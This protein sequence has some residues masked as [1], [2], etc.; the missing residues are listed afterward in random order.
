MQEIG[1]I[2]ILEQYLRMLSPEL[3]VW[4]KEHNPNSAAEAALLA[5]VYVAARRKGQPWSHPAWK[6]RDV[7]TSASHY[8]I[9]GGSKSPM[10]HSL[11]VSSTKT[12]ICYLCG[13]EGHTK[14]RCPRNSAQITQMCFVP[15]QSVEPKVELEKVLKIISVELNGKTLKALLDSGSTQTLIHRN[16]VPANKVNIAKTIRVCCVHGD[17]KPYTTADMHIKVQGQIYLV[18]IGVA[19]NLPFPAVL[20]VLF[21][22]LNTNHTCNV[23]VTRAQAMEKEE[24]SHTL[25]ALPF[26]DSDLE[27]APGKSRKSR[28]QSTQ[29]KFQHIAKYSSDI[30]PELPLGFKIPVNINEMQHGDPALVPLFKKA[31]RKQRSGQDFIS[32]E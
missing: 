6:M 7:Q 32:R 30:E 19:E 14:P 10:S 28:R 5:D 15:R 4:I 2:L 25:C 23:A 29:E 13:M 20:P 18:N 9:A 8:Q 11:N 16:F 22:L 26:H 12:V 1:E 31:E 27:T 21:D 24:L 3:Q 17:E